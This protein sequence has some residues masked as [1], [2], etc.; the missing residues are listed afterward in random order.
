[1]IPS[2]LQKLPIVGEGRMKPT[3]EISFHAAQATPPVGVA[4]S[5]VARVDMPSWVVILTVV[6]LLVQISYL[7]WKWIREAMA[8]AATP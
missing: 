7:L 4:A 8:R 6:Y 5:I 2:I 3:A 1:M